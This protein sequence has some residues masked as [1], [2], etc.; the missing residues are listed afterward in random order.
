VSHPVVLIVGPTGVGKSDFALTAAENLN[1][2]ILNCDSLQAYKRLDIGTAKPSLTDRR[3]VPH[4]LFDFIEPGGHL[5][6]GDYRREA[7]EILAKEIPEHPVLAVGGSGFYIQALE[8]GMFDVSKPDPLIEQKVREDLQSQG[9]GEL[10]KE[11]VSR[12]SEY[13]EEINPNDSYRIVRG[14]VV[15]REKGIRVSDLRKQ[16]KPLPFP[17]PLIKMGFECDRE[18]LKV[19]IEHRSEKMLAS[20]LLNEVTTLVNEGF[21]DW[22]PLMSVG[23]KECLDV[24]EH[25]MPEALLKQTIVEKTMQLA[26]KQMTWFRRDKAI[27]WFQTNDDLTAPMNWLKG[28]LSSLTN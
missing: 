7:L 12:D 24:I 18:K 8:K 2:A 19:R 11:L 14:L 3:R 1:A 13:A 6:A 27:T 23:Y 21:R 9:L 10:W 17:H 15:M 20:G 25:R 28:R 26:K 22:P 4:F 5:T 16:F